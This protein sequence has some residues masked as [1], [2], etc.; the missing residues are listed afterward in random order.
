MKFSSSISLWR[1]WLRHL[2]VP[3]LAAALCINANECWADAKEKIRCVSDDRDVRQ[4]Y[5]G[6]GIGPGDAEPFVS[7]Y[8]RCFPRGYRQ[9]PVVTL[10]SSGGSVDA[11]IKISA[12]LRRESGRT[13]IRTRVADNGVCISACTYIFLSGSFREVPQGA[14]FEPHGF[15]G[16]SG[17]AIQNFM[18]MSADKLAASGRNIQTNRLRVALRLVR[19]SSTAEERSLEW[20]KS[21]VQALG[22][23]TIDKDSRVV[24]SL[25]TTGVPLPLIYDLDAALRVV[26]PELEREVAVITLLGRMN[27]ERANFRDAGA[28]ARHH[29]DWIAAR[30]NA[31]ADKYWGAS[32]SK[33]ADARSGDVQNEIASIVSDR[34]KSTRETSAEQLWPLMEALKNE[35]NI[36]ALTRLMFSTS[37]LYT[38][39]L[40]REELCDT[41]IVNVG[42]Q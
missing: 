37:I 34:I 23:G 28:I 29:T 2:P 9:Q 24:G 27:A 20:N 8:S 31:A 6:G 32:R 42:C 3:I 38:R 14:S 4:L 36:E 22:D 11:A 18:S 15:S 17:P 26:M 40:T 12:F 39:P 41:N 10:D 16:Y 19:A 7:E 1:S 5:F 30:L 33:R 25:R 35:V 21:V 13:P